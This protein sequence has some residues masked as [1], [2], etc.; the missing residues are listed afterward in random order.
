MQD[1]RIR[2]LSHGSL[3]MLWSISRSKGR[4]CTFRPSEDR[5]TPVSVPSLSYV[6]TFA[7]PGRP[8]NNPMLTQGKNMP[9]QIFAGVSRTK[10]SYPSKSSQ[11]SAQ[12]PSAVTSSNNSSPTTLLGI[13]GSSYS[14]LLSCMGVGWLSVQS[15]WLGVRIW[16]RVTRCISGFTWCSW[17]LCEHFLSLQ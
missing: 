2:L 9:V 15:G 14:A 6:S 13:I 12:D 4:F 1:G 3:L 7:S 16:T 10:Q 17:I 8:A 11:Y 5:S